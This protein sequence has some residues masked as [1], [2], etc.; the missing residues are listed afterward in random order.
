MRA[1]YGALFLLLLLQGVRSQETGSCAQPTPLCC[2]GENDDCKRGC[3]CD[4][5]CSQY[6]E[7]CSDYTETCAQR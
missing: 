5:A 7:C 3:S 4:E 2:T 6:N 1:V